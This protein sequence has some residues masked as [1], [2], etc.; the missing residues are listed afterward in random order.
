MMR[1]LKHEELTGK[2]RQIAFEVH[3]YFRNGFLEK[4]YENALMTR[5]RKAGLTVQQQV[6]MVVHDEDGTIVGEY[7]ADLL[8]EGFLVIELKAVKKL[9]NEHMAQIIN[10]LKSTRLEPWASESSCHA[11]ADEDERHPLK[12]PRDGKTTE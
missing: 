3:K 1:E 5:L 4:V 9:L 6:L 2:I 7:Y 10:Y 11:E 8:V 12:T